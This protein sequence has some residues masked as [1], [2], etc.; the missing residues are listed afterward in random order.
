M[1]EI[2]QGVLPS[3]VK[4]GNGIGTESGNASAFTTNRIVRNHRHIH[5]KG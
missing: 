5:L 2:H 1:T 3:S 4:E